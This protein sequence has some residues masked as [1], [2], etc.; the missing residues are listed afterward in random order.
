MQDQ[1]VCWFND[2][3]FR[4][5]RVLIGMV[6]RTDSLSKTVKNE[7]RKPRWSQQDAYIL[8]HKYVQGENPPIKC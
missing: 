3:S 7:G 8:V 5:I 2:L 6:I 1:V 4:E